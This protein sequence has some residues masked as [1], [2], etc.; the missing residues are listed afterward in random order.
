M[1]RFSR[2]FSISPS[3][4]VAIVAVILA[5]GG[6]SYAA[7]RL[8]RNSVGTQQLRANAV[9][10]SDVLD[11][12]LQLRDLSLRAREALR[13]T[14]AP[15]GPPAPTTVGSQV[16][17][18]MITVKTAAGVVPEAPD[19]DTRVT[20]PAVTATCDPGQRVTGGGV[21]LEDF[22]NT[23]V[24]DSYPSANGTAWTAHVGNDE[25]D[26]NNFTVYAVCAS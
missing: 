9:R 11:R 3:M 23:S 26:P 22:A 25:T 19:P 18:S 16:Q 20:S 5:L 8:P 6:T 2:R 14:S 17:I 24:H 1:R 4:V 7:L 21:S 13:G 15:A 12:S 10:S